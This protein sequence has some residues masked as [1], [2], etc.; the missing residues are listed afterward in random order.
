MK[1]SETL[2]Q[3]A[4]IGMIRLCLLTVFMGLVVGSCGQRGPLY[5]PQ[6]ETAAGNAASASSPTGQALEG[7]EDGTGDET[8]DEDTDE[9]TP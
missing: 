6:K 9:E 5:L 7:T 4:A 8:E 2:T 3:R 1:T